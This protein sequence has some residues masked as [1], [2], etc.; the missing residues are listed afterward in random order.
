MSNLP[1]PINNELSNLRRVSLHEILDAYFNCI[2]ICGFYVK[3]MGVCIGE[4]LNNITFVHAE[5]GV[6]IDLN[7]DGSARIRHE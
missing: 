5:T 6:K 7:N 1:A 2:P 4:G 3:K